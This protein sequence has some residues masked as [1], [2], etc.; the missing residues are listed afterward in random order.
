MQPAQ[1]SLMPDACPAPPGMVLDDLPERDVA[2]AIELIAGLIAK[3]TRR[4]DDGVPKPEVHH[5]E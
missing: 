1:L 3:R 4:D 2:A 5:G